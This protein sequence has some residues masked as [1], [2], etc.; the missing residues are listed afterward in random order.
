MASWRMLLDHDI[1]RRDFAKYLVI[2]DHTADLN[3]ET[4]GRSLEHRPPISSMRRLIRLWENLG[5]LP[6]R[7]HSHYRGSRVGVAPL[8]PIAVLAA[9][10]LEPVR[11]FWSLILYNE[12]H[13]FHPNDLKRYSLGTKNKNLKRN[14]IGMYGMVVEL[15]PR[16]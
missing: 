4:A 9:K 2:F 3:V 7:C 11:G 13:F 15:L 8:D 16:C 10:Q 1:R 5:L 6:A 14:S 12:H